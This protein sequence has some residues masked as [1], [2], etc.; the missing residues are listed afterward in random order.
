[1]LVD[2]LYELRKFKLHV[3]SHEWLALMEAMDK[4]L[5]DSSLDGF[6]AKFNIING[7]NGAGKTSVIEALSVAALTKSFTNAPDGAAAPLWT[8]PVSPWNKCSTGASL[9]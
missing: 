4:G 6:G 2:F 3:S 8:R 1:M 7:Q 9:V 5:H